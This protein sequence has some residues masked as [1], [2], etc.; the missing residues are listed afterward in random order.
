MFIKIGRVAA[1]AMSII[2]S[3]KGVNIKFLQWLRVLVNCKQV[4]FSPAQGKTFSL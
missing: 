3:V 1:I 4:P 2:S